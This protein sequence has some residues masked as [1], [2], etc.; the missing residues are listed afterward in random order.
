[1]NHDKKIKSD[2]K[3]YHSSDAYLSLEASSPI[4]RSL[5]SMSSIR[6]AARII[7][8]PTKL[9]K[10][11]VGKLE[12]ANPHLTKPVPLSHTKTLRPWLSIAAFDVTI[13]LTRSLFK[14]DKYQID[15]FRLEEMITL[16]PSQSF[17]Q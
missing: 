1:M 8:L 6:L 16:Q 17:R 5:T 13:A 7:G 11:W 4:I 10:I 2:K 14:A 3:L 9:G 15:D 12:P